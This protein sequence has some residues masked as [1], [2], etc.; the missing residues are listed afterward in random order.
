MEGRS[1]PRIKVRNIPAIIRRRGFPF[2]RGRQEPAKVIDI[3]RRGLCLVCES[4]LDPDTRLALTV[5]IPDKRPIRCGGIVRNRRKSDVGYV[6]GVEF[7][8]LSHRDRRFLE[9]NML[10][11]AGVDALETCRLLKDRVRGMRTAMGL[12]VS[13]LSELTGVSPQRIVQIEFGMEKTPPDDILKRIAAGLGVS[14]EDLI[15]EEPGGEEE[16]TAEILA[17]RLVFP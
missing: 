6:L 3:G 17:S 12:T 4:P 14:R 1:S 2:K 15:G 16:L 7:T 10:E 11:I 5:M 8:R 9:K 13:E